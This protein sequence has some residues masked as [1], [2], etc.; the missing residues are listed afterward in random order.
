[1]ALFADRR[2]A[3]RVLAHDLERWRGSD[4]VVLGIPR[5][6]VVTAAAVAA[7]LGLPLDVILV[8][9]LGATGHEEFAVGAIAD[10]VRL[11]EPSAVRWAGMSPSDVDDV[12]AAERDELARRSARFGSGRVDL[13]GRTAIVVDDGVA[14]GSSA[15]AACR[16]VRARSPRRVVLAVPVS[17]ERFTPPADVVDEFVC[18]HREPDFWAVGQYYDDFAQTTDA[19]VVQL[20]GD[21]ATGSG[22]ASGS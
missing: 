19:E 20:L 2:A 11:V 22:T 18:P 15:I 3:G 17:P 4:A 16:A 8:R 9:K 21:R 10:G 13:A 6:G 7:H 5:G 12:E 14:T 1:M